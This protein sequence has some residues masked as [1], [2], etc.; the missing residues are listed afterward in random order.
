[1]DTTTR[2][3]LRSTFGPTRAE[4]GDPVRRLLAWLGGFFATG[5]ALT[6]G[7]VLAVF[8][9]AAVAVI[10]VFASVLVFLAGLALRAR[11]VTYARA[12]APGAGGTVLEARKVGH[13]WVAYGWDRSAR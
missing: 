5:A 2:I 4:R 10:A 13:S 9:A 1:M 8:T 7:A 12:R 6:I 3:A 11:R